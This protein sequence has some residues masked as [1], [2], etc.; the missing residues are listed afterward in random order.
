M[1]DVRCRTEP[2]GTGLAKAMESRERKCTGP[3]VKSIELV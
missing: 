1:C 3:L 2:M